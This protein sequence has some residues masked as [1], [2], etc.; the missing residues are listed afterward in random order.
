M[1][2]ITIKIPTKETLL[3][4]I[5]EEEKIRQSKEYQNECTKVKDIPNGWLDVTKKIQEDLV[6]K[7]GFDDDISCEVAC[8]RLR[9]AQYLYPEENRFKTTPLYVRNNKAN[10]GTL[11]IN[12]AIPDMNLYD[13][14]NKQTTLYE[15]MDKNKPNII[16]AGSHT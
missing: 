15:L 2:Q 6:R 16:F 4:I 3:R 13:L 5:D 7:Y 1:D 10:K 11:Q 8:N 9:R 12:S 14:T